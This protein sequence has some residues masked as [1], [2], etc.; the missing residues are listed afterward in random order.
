MVGTFTQKKKD[1]T[2]GHKGAVSVGFYVVVWVACAGG[3]F[4]EVAWFGFFIVLIS[5][6]CWFNF[7]GFLILWLDI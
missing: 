3:F 4:V 7:M 2:L 5:F 6:C 1:C